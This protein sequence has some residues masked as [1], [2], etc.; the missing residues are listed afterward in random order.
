M[1]TRGRAR[2]RTL[3]ASLNKMGPTKDEGTTVVTRDLVT[4]INL[5]DNSLYFTAEMCISVSNLLFQNSV[6][7]SELLGS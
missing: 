2:F 1:F 6:T 4:D 3:F 5:P 7:I